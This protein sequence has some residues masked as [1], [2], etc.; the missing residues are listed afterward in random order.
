[1]A[2]GEL[3]RR[4]GDARRLARIERSGQAGPYVAEGAGARAGIAHD[5]ERRV[6]LLPTLAD[7]RAAGLLAHRMQ[8]VR[9]HDR[10]RLQIAARDRR[11]DSDPVWLLERRRVRP[12]R[13][14]GVARAPAR[15]DG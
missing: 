11:L 14:L 15:A 12:M 2:E 7:V 3:R 9:A 8:A 1:M 6:L 13:L 10:T 5:H 4:L